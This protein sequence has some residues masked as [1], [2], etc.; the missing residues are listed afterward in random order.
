MKANIQKKLTLLHNLWCNSVLC[1]CSTGWSRGC[2]GG[3]WGGDNS[4]WSA[5]KNHLLLNV[6]RSRSDQLR[7]SSYSSYRSRHFNW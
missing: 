1:G 4:L 3:A 6:L 5:L 2:H 7:S